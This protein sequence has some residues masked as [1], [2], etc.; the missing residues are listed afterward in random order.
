VD[1][2]YFIAAFYYFIIDIIICAEK[3]IKA[4]PGAIHLLN[5]VQA[6]SAAANAAP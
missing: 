6:L 5:A 4:A 3:N 2:L 1:N